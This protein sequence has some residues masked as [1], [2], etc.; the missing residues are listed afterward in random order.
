M[1]E[2]RGP[3]VETSPKFPGPPRR[4][5]YA[6]IIVLMV[7][8]IWYLGFALGNQDQSVIDKDILG[9]WK[10]HTLAH[11]R[12]YD[13]SLV[14]VSRGP[15]GELSA[16]S[17]DLRPSS[18]A[19]TG[20]EEIAFA[21]GILHSSIPDWGNGRFVF[22][23]RMSEDKNSIQ[24]TSDNQ[25][26]REWVRV[27][28][29]ETIS[30]VEGFSLSYKAV[31]KREYEYN[32]PAET[33]DG[34]MTG[35]LSE[36]RIDQD[37]IAELLNRIL[38]GKYD[39]IHDLL[40]AKDGR[41]VLEEYFRSEGRI[42]GPLVSDFYR[43]RKHL[44]ASSTKSITSTLIGVAVEKGF[45]RDVEV[46]IF[47]FFPEYAHLDN[48]EKHKIRLKH[49]LTMTAGLDWDQ[50]SDVTGMWET[51]DVIGYCLGKSAVAEPGREFN[52]SNGIS[53]L[54]GAVIA[55][56]SGMGADEF[57]GQYLFAP[58][59][60]SDFDWSEY[61]DGTIDTDGSLA[62]RPRDLVKIGLLFLQ[63]GR[64]N[65]KEIISGAWI[66]EATAKHLKYTE[67]RGY[68]YQWWQTDFEVKGRTVGSFHSWGWG[69]QYLVVF[70]QLDLIVVS[71]AGN[72]D[73]ESEQY[74]FTMIAEHILPAV[75]TS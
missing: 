61:P 37:E 69:G 55:N 32:P 43:D 10:I 65:G 51:D 31:G 7:S 75:L 13:H 29:A 24:D 42:Y 45:I 71:H 16:L 62:L 67:S 64:W 52:Y 56:A 59:G 9:I 36:A 60:I 22:E 30:I 50:S 41:L 47:E 2:Q 58:L 14:K 49:M 19:S 40:I 1:K 25:Y 54:L 12:K 28:D 5:C 26:K 23:G 6:A 15:K 35:G 20:I 39:D 70:P 46:P 72:F 63:N 11:G 48:R 44:L 38:A 4:V 33:D 21:D 18:L 17:I 34:I 27:T 74:L 68:G 66:A 8:R 73:D 3:T 57:S 53:T